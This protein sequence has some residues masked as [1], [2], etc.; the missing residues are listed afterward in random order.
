MMVSTAMPISVSRFR[1]QLY[2]TAPDR[3][4]HHDR[5]TAAAHVSPRCPRGENG[6]RR[7]TRPAGEG[8]LPDKARSRPGK[9]AANRKQVGIPSRVRTKR[10][11][12]LLYV[13][14]ST[15]W[16][17]CLVGGG[18]GRWVGGSFRAWV[19]DFAPAC[20]R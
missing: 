5:D 19:S 2:R 6:R 14:C 18:V 11:C 7:R 15:W 3:V 10:I 20:S 4:R 13:C 8:A 16:L 1:R 9:A 12:L 17:G